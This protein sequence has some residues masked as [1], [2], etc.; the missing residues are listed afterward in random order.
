MSTSHADPRQVPLASRPERRR[1]ELDRVLR[2]QRRL[3]AGLVQLLAAAV[4]IALGFLLPQSPHRVRH[5]GQ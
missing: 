3:R 2:R 4:A 5:P 1:H